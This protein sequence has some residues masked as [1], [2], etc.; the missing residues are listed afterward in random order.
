MPGRSSRAGAGERGQ[1]ATETAVL[2]GLLALALIIAV[3]FM[4]TTI[5]HAFRGE[6]QEAGSVFKPP[7]AQC[8]TNYSGA[9]IPPY[10]P[11]VDCSDLETLGITEFTVSGED[12]HDL[13][14]DGDGIGCS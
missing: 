9:C 8:D 3:V 6:S 13:D 11:D 4:R 10:P 14:S 2:V 7:A 1:A 12:P 5:A